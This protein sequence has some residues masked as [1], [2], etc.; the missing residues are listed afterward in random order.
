MHLNKLMKICCIN[1][2]QTQTSFSL[3]DM[4]FQTEVFTKVK[5]SRSEMQTENNLKHSRSERGT[6]YRNGTMEPY[7]RDSG[8]TTKRVVKARSGMLKETY[9]WVS[10]KTIKLMALENILTSTGANILASGSMM[11]KRARVKKC[12][13]MER[14]IKVITKMVKNMDTVSISG[15]M[16][17]NSLEIGKTTKSQGLESTTGVMAEFMKAT[18]KKTKCTDRVFIDGP[19]AECTTEIMSTTKKKAMVNTLTLTDDATKEIG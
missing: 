11:F 3:T 8:M 1:L 2:T 13:Q 14:S 12:G 16:V 9:M 17:V 10:F 15:Q 6:E 18:G 4:N 7:M 19:T 5:C